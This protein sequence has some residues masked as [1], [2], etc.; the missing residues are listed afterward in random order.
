MPA[1]VDSLLRAGHGQRAAELLVNSLAQHTWPAE[2]PVAQWLEQ[3]LGDDTRARLIS[4]FAHYP[5][6]VCDNGFERCQPCGGSGFTAVAQVCVACI[7]LGSRRC[8]F[9]NGAGLATYNV[10]PLELRAR[11]TVSRASRGAKYL[12]ALVQKRPRDLTEATASRYLIDMNKLLGVLE[13]AVIA[14]RQLADVGMLPHAVAA[15]MFAACSKPAAAAEIRVRETLQ[16]L[17]RHHADAAAALPPVDAENA[18][19]KGEFYS[20]LSQSDGF[21]GTGIAHPFLRAGGDAGE[22]SAST[23]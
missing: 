15:N 10:V 20:M 16:R 3:S 12:K 21:E 14:A 18:R 23:N 1:K 19:A 13:N 17:A 6:F 22:R 4:A 7:G 2:L 5:C 8:D 11:V 9:C